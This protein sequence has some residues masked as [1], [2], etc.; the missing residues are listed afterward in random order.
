MESEQMH[1]RIM[2]TLHEKAAMGE[3]CNA[4]EDHEAIMDMLQRRIATGEGECGGYAKGN[5]SKKQYYAMMA[6]RKYTTKQIDVKYKELLKKRRASRKPARKRAVRKRAVGTTN[7][8][9]PKG[10]IDWNSFRSMYKG[11]RC[12]PGQLSDLY[13]RSRGESRPVRF[14]PASCDLEANMPINKPVLYPNNPILYPNPYLNNPDIKRI[15]TQNV[16]LNGRPL[17]QEQKIALLSYKILEDEDPNKVNNKALYDEA[18]RKILASGEGYDMDDYYD[19][20]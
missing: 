2:S 8:R 7:R 5:I 16:R 17:T 3:G 18:R 10:P 1:N 20:Y 4:N 12:T 9:L 11:R 13:A 6:S 15:T 14:G 19:M